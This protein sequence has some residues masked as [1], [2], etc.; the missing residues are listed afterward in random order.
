MP[1]LPKLFRGSLVV[2]V[3]LLVGAA[4]GLWALSRRDAGTAALK[5]TGTIEATQVDVGP[6]A[7][8]RI[9]EIRAEEGQRVRRGELL[10]VLDD[11]QLRAEVARLEAAHDVARAQLKDLLAGARPEEIRAARQAVLQ[12]EARLRDLEA[13][14]RRQEIEQARS[15]VASAE[16]TR[17]MADREYERLQSLLDRGLIAAQDRDRAW[18]AREVAR[19]QE[20]A[21]RQQLDLLLSG[22]RPEQVEAARAEVRQARDRLALVEAGPRAGQV[23][24]A[25]AQ[26]AQAEAAV[27]EARARL[28]DARIES[29]TDGVVLRKNLE[30]GATATPGTPVLTLVDQKTLWLRAYVPEVDLGRVR[31]G[32][33]AH[34]AVD[35]FPGQSFA[36]RVTEIA[37]EAEFTPRNVQTQKERVNLVFRV[38]IS[39]TNPDGR[40]KPGMP[41]D[42]VLVTDG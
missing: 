23:E 4:V 37:S 29:P 42:A 5:V 33:A 41:A 11:D 10:I 39:V 12:A 25:R 9:R 28:A 20:R 31:L 19:A 17:T 18:Q 6:K 8:A 32:Q 22:P 30:P 36:A 34:V 16:A 7:T 40:L 21:A 1:T 26:V 38:K 35:A 15:A 3:L 2:V 24:T 27:A 14:A 13:G